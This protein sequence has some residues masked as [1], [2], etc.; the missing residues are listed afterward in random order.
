MG[1]NKSRYTESIIND[2]VTREETKIGECQ[3]CKAD[4]IEIYEKDDTPGFRSKDKWIV[5]NCEC[6]NYMDK[7][8]KELWEEMKEIHLHYKTK[9][10]PK[11]E[12]KIKNLK[13]KLEIY[14]TGMGICEECEKKFDISEVEYCEKCG[15][16]L[17][18]KCNEKYDGMCL[19]CASYDPYDY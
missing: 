15:L 6:S 19:E 10:I 8:K 5:Y 11:Y 12:E 1:A 16:I 2:Y 13:E 3:H 9:E 14:K 7:S 17:C 18:P 4:I